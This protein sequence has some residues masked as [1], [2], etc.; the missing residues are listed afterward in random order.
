MTHDMNGHYAD[1][2]PGEQ[3]TDPEVEAAVRRLAENGRMSCAQAHLISEELKTDP[4]TVGFH[5]DMTETRITR[6]QLGL[7]GYS[8][9]KKIVRPADEVDEFSAENVAMDVFITERVERYVGGSRQ[10]VLDDLTDFA[11]DEG[12]SNILVVVGEAGSGKSALLSKFCQDSRRR[13]PMC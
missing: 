12:E 6:C 9:K 4:E 1:K 11:N 5:L 8:P 13:I 10:A 3:S 7:F 2:H